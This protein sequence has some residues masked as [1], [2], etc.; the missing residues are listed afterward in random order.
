[1]IA[2][3]PHPRERRRPG[4]TLSLLSVAAMSYILQQTLVVPALPTIQRELHTSTTWVTWVF[5]GFLL[6]SAV[7][8][9]LL[10]RLGDMYGKKRLLVIAMAVFAIGTLWAAV[11][12]SIAMLIAARA[13]Q[14]TAGAIFPLSFGIIRDEFPRER[15]AMALGLL[16]ATFGVGAGLGLVLS[17]VIL[18]NL[19]W[20]WLFWI[21]VMP[22]IGALLLV[23]RLVPESPIRT[24]ARL[25]PLGALTLS[26]GLVALLV[27]LSEGERWGW[28]SAATLGCFAAA[29]VVLALW[30]RVELRVPEPLVDIG[31]MRERAVFWTNVLAVVAGF[32]MFASFVL[33][34]TLVQLGHG[35]P[36]ELAARVDFGLGTSVITAGLFLL[37]A[38][39]MML[40]VGPVAGLLEARV[41]ARTL[42][43]AGLLVLGIGAIGLSAAHGHGW[44]I[45]LE[46][47]V[48][49]IGVGLVY[50]ML[51]KLIVDAVPRE[52]TGIA[53]GMNT[54]MRTIG[55][56]IGGQV[57]AAL[58]SSFVVSGTALPAE[59]G[60]TLTFLLAG[61]VAV[62]GAFGA[63]RIPSRR[64]RVVAEP[65]PAAT[66]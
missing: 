50:A 35:L 54:V 48:I 11:A 45:V 34:P 42:V 1:M 41:G 19:D 7:A 44:Q 22:V 12:S 8:T 10:G 21:G 4:V 37:P 36:E 40:V 2:P 25:D 30:V 14:G 66:G 3:E 26:V 38:S 31:L 64:W 61:L 13:L 5:T 27:G 52:V 33:T 62:V 28:L 53:M 58:L 59:T 29:L 47:A 18:E 9:P 20:P 15:V 46:M 51:A 24:P 57:G 39:L 16:S 60:F 56:V 63:W 65:G 23:M 6:T 55:S 43:F 17:G 49:G 32:V